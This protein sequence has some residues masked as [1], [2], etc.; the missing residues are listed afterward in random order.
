MFKKFAIAAFAGLS[1]ILTA[2]SARAQAPLTFHVFRKGDDIGTQV[3]SFDKQG[4]TV[5]VTTTTRIAVK[6]L[7]VTAYKFT[8]DG[9]ETWKAGKLTEL[10]AHTNDNGE[11]H[12]VHVMPKGGGLVLV[13]DGKTYG[14]PLTRCPAAGGMK[15]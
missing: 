5:K 6:V 12:D 11:K 8:F 2:A 7:F 1:L 14:I 13:A 15:N 9:T 3:I 10:D 4:D